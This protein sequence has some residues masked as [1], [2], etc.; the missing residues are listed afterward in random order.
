MWPA[1]EV[2]QAKFSKGL[3]LA[4]T[5]GLKP[6]SHHFLFD[7]HAD[8]ILGNAIGPQTR[9][10]NIQSRNGWKHNFL[11]YGQ[12][13]ARSKDSE[14]NQT[15][16]VQAMHSLRSLHRAS[17]SVGGFGFRLVDDLSSSW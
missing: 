6:K 15:G 9:T 8:H 2:I 4:T 16:D 5:I 11:E 7:S 17:F 3:A 1:Y 10:L 12:A 14:H 13:N